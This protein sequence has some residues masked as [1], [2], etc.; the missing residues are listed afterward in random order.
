MQPCRYAIT[1]AIMVVMASTRLTMLKQLSIFSPHRLDGLQATV[2]HRD[3][4]P[5]HTGAGGIVT[6]PFDLL[7]PGQ[8][9]VHL[10][11]GGSCPR[12]GNASI[13]H[14]VAQAAILK[15]EVIVG[16]D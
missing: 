6:L 13:V 12:G 5:M 4:T 7:E 10:V 8:E 14:M 11:L 3:V 1:P 9:L 16:G 15:L 2:P